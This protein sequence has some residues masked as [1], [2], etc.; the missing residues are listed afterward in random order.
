MTKNLESR[1]TI[2]IES[3]EVHSSCHT[4]ETK[5]QSNNGGSKDIPHDAIF[6]GNLSYFC[7]EEILSSLFSRFGVVLSVSIQRSRKNLPLHYGFLDMPAADAEK[8]IRALNNIVFMG[9]QLRYTMD[10]LLFLFFYIISSS[11]CCF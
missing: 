11:F 3:M 9:R 10:M 8:A 4:Q 1:D 2:K 6:V 7:T 5:S